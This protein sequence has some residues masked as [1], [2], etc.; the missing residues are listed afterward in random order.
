MMQQPVMTPLDVNNA[1][2]Q[3]EAQAEQLEALQEAQAAGAMM[4]QQA[5]SPTPWQYP[6]FPA[7]AMQRGR[8]LGS[9]LMAGAV[10]MAGLYVLSRFYNVDIQKRPNKIDEL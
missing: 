9:Y 2:A 5:I 10:V 7:Q 3:A 6:P 1:L 8:P 4:P